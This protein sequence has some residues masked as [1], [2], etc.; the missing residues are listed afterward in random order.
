MLSEL[1]GTKVR[2]VAPMQVM[3][4]GMAAVESNT[5]PLFEGWGEGNVMLT[6]L[7]DTAKKGAVF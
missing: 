1:A 7:L 2:I 4:A 6:E 5:E 3:Q